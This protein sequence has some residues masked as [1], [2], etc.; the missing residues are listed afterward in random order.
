MSRASI[1][2]S[3]TEKNALDAASAD[4]GCY[5]QALGVFDLR[6]MTPE[7]WQEFIKVTCF[8]YAENMRDVVEDESPPL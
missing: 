5:L 8:S 6:Q 3:T 2:I 1:D 4:A 7:D